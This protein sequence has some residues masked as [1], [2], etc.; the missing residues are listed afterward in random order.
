MVIDSGEKLCLSS[1][2]W[3]RGPFSNVC[4]S[5]EYEGSSLC[6]SF[7]CHIETRSKFREKI[8]DS[9]RFHIFE[10]MPA[11]QPEPDTDGW[12]QWIA[13]RFGS[14]HQSSE[15]REHRQISKT[16]KFKDFALGFD[17][18]SLHI[19]GKVKIV[20]ERNKGTDILYFS[21]LRYITQKLQT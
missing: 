4:V 14:S 10:S 13:R 7:S 2:E 20:E 18:D 3:I 1:G 17:E 11:Q 19:F 8:R 9:A 5:L 12:I 16:L 21:I 6:S 15:G